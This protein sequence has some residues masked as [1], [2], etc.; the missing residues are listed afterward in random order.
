MSTPIDIVAREGA[1]LDYTNDMTYGDY[2][3]LDS[4]LSS[5]QPLSNLHDEMLF[6][7]QHQT[8]ELWMKLMLHELQAAMNALVEGNSALA[9]KMMARVSRIMAQLVSAWDVLATMTPPEYSALRP[10]LANSSGFQSAQYRCIE[11]T[12]GNKNAAMLKPHAHRPELLATVQKAFDSPSLY[13]IAIA[14]LAAAGL[15]IDA[16]HLKRDWRVSHTS[17]ANV[18]SAWK[19]VYQAPDRYWDLYQLGEKLTDIEDTFRQWRFRHLTT[20]ERVIG[21]RRGTGGT[22]GTGYLRAMLDVVLF[23]EIWQMRSE[24]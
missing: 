24:L 15:P 20:V 19:V 10:H 1:K 13:D 18:Q 17:S 14:R 16:V 12:L 3:H 2:L 8:S 6:I 4:L 9:F 22:S 11:F 7:V 21:M 5:Q 23:P